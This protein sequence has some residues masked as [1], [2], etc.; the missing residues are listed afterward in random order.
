MNLSYDEIVAAWVEKY[1]KLIADEQFT[2]RF[3]LAKASFKD[4]YEAALAQQAQPVCDHGETGSHV[5]DAWNHPNTPPP[6]C[7]GPQQAQPLTDE[8]KFATDCSHCGSPI[9]IDDLGSVLGV[10]DRMA[11]PAQPEMPTRA[12]GDFRMATQDLPGDTPMGDALALF[13]PTREPFCDDCNGLGGAEGRRCSTCGVRGPIP[14]TCNTPAAC[15][16]GYSENCPTHK[17]A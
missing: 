8:L 17:S 14:P 2:D 10:R 3:Y 5:Y 6:K 13:A 11:Q 16:N 1:R 4:G 15:G 12:L 7:P 9:W